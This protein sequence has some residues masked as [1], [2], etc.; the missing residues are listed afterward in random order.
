[1]P[2]RRR[3]G[4]K[5]E[6]L[7]YYLDGMRTAEQGAGKRLL[8]VLDL[9]F[10]SEAM[11]SEGTLIGLAS[12]DPTSVNPSDGLIQAR[13]QAPR[14]LSEADY[15]ENSWIT[16]DLINAKPL[17]LIPWLKNK[18]ANHYP[19][20]KLAFTEY[21]YGGTTHISGAIAQADVLGIFAREGVFAANY[22]ELVSPGEYVY[23]AFDAY[24]N[25]DGAGSK[26][27]DTSVSA[28]TSDKERIAVHATVNAGDN[29]MVYVI[30][31][32]K[33]AADVTSTIAITHPVML[34]HADVYQLTSKAPRLLAAEPATV[35][36]NT[37]SYTLP[38]YSVSTIV[39][40]GTP[41]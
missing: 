8:N 28:L 33:S 26:V 10:Y 3:F 4:G 34:T 20:T 6:F 11:S 17:N 37:L 15:V 12:L 38:A 35:S 30:A 36:S 1:L 7:D 25:F 2:T 27:G 29:S 21:S 22:Y 39:L 32:N 13:V 14:S 5:G 40:R 31:I 16:R 9:H 23:A 19:D 24:L 18:I 41:P